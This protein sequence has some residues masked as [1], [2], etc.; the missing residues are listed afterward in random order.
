MEDATF[1]LKV[2]DGSTVCVKLLAEGSEGGVDCD[3]GSA[4]DIRLTQTRP[5]SPV[6]ETGLGLDAGTGAATLSVPVAIAQLPSGTSVED[7]AAATFGL[8]F[9]LGM[10]TGSTSATIANTSQGGSVSIVAGGESFDC[11]AWTTT[12]GPG[13]LAGAFTELDNPVA[14]DTANALLLAD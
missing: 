7:C 2:V 4:V 3:G 13:T 11:D 8:P 12:D 14:G 5:D 10:T 1:G 6:R 9:R